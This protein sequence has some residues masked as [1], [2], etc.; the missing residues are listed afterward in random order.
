MADEDSILAARQQ[1]RRDYY[2]AN[3]E[4][5]KARTIAW[6]AANKE[7]KAAADKAYR[8]ANP[9]RCKAKAAEWCEKNR[10]K[11]IE[12]W[13]RYRV[14]KL[15][16]ARANEAAYRARNRDECNARIREWKQRNPHK[17]THYFHKRRAA[18]L[19]AM[20]AWADIRAI[21]AIYALAQMVQAMS[22][23]PQHVDHIVPLLGK[24]V[25]GLHCE[26]N[27]QVI[28][29]PDNLK[30]NNRHWPDMP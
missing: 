22:G 6:T 1:Y 10:E 29:A 15:D 7:R 26:A 17:L 30:K 28:P 14:D 4:K 23:K 24:T 16:R 5:I 11:R 21:E 12:I 20:P 27:L 8:E 25:C 3:K 9:E 2:Q 13:Q 18:E 19:R